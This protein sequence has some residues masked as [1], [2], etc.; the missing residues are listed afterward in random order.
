M[1]TNTMQ[2]DHPPAAIPWRCFVL[3]NFAMLVDKADQQLLPAVFLEVCGELH[4]GPALLGT[5]TLCRGMAMSLVAV[6]A[7]PLSRRFDR[8]SICVAGMTLWAIATAAVG[9][10]PSISLLLVGRTINGLGALPSN[11]L[12]PLAACYIASSHVTC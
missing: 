10:A 8:V 12:V 1:F 2:P 9:A 7:G 3:L 6:L 5:V 11:C 4:A